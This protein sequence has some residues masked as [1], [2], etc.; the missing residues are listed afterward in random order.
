MIYIYIYSS[1]WLQWHPV[2]PWNIWVNLLVYEHNEVKENQNYMYIS[3]D[4]IYKIS[5]AYVINI[6]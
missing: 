5:G 1:D 6:D 2:N 4:V 3:W